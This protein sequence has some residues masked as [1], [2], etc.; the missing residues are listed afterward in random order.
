MS[1]DKK[2]Q[3]R[4]YLTRITKN[5]TNAEKKLE[6]AEAN[7]LQAKALKEKATRELADYNNL[8]TNQDG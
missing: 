7:L 2:D 1:L 8:A 3:E 6:R 4:A 5:L